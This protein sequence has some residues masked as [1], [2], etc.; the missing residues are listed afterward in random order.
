VCTCVFLLHQ[1]SFDVILTTNPSYQM[2]VSQGSSASWIGWGLGQGWLRIHPRSAAATRV[3]LKKQRQDG[4]ARPATCP[5]CSSS[6]SRCSPCSF[7]SGDKVP[8]S[9]RCSSDKC[10]LEPWPHSASM[11][12]ALFESSSW[13][14][15]ATNFTNNYLTSIWICTS[16]DIKVFEWSDCDRNRLVFEWGIWVKKACSC[17][18]GVYLLLAAKFIGV[19][20]ACSCFNP[21][22][23]SCAN[24][25]SIFYYPYIDRPWWCIRIFLV[26]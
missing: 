10:V 16:W 9:S 2:R 4:G 14:C 21:S 12:G 7:C 13:I 20:W 26:K 1:E 15:A 8:C 11:D 23:W 25:C 3:R 24:W 17:C 5:P 6:S 18:V 19:D 22:S